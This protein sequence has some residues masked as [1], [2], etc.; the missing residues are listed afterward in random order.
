[1]AKQ[2]GFLLGMTSQHGEQ[3]VGILEIV[4]IQPGA[5]DRHSLMVQGDQSVALGMLT[6]C[7]VQRRQLVIPQHAM[8]FA[9]Y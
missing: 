6:Q 1:M 4:L 2:D 3:V 8:G 5:T 7:A 9:A